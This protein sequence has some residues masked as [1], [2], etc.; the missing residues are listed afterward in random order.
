MWFLLN[1][2]KIVWISVFEFLKITQP[3]LRCMES[4]GNAPCR[5]FFKSTSRLI[6]HVVSDVLMGPVQF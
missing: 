3:E 6:L 5:T 1:V 4:Y 2:F